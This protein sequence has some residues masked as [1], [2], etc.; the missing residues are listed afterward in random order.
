MRIL[1]AARLSQAKKGQT[2]IDTQDYH[3]REWAEREGH[4]VVAV[5]ADKKRGTTH[6]W[7]RPNL[8]PWMTKPDLLAQYDA[9]LG[10]KIDRLSRGDDESTSLIE[11]WAREH[12]KVLLT[13][14]GLYYPCEGADGIRWDV[15]KRLAHQEWLG[16]SEK[17]K[18][19]QGYLRDNNLHAGGRIP[20]GFRMVTKDG[21]EHKT[22]EPD[23]A[24]AP[25]V[26]QAIDR[27]IAGESLQKVC[28]WL[29]GQGMK[30]WQAE[31]W[32]PGSLK[33]VF[34]NESLYGRMVNGKGRT[35]LRHEG[36]IDK[37]KYDLLQD[38]LHGK[39]KHTG[40]M[41][42]DTAMLTNIAACLNCGGPMYRHVSGRKRAD[43]S[44]IRYLYYRCHGDERNPSQCK[45]M[46]PLEELEGWVDYHMTEGPDRLKP[47]KWLKVIPGHG[48]L[49]ELTEL[50]RDIRELD[51]D[52]PEYPAKAAELHAK[53]VA[54][55]ALPAV[56]D[57]VVEQDTGLTVADY[58]RTLDAPGRRAF[59][60]AS[61]ARVRASKDG[62]TVE[63]SPSGYVVPEAA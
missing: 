27:Y 19:M 34:I 1:I 11:Q 42:T 50:E 18:R 7:D 41:G 55:K 53:R 12:G 23:P 15:M 43:G 44:K 24:K 32:S 45:N 37:T 25:F 56:P 63:V 33:R 52:D 20:Y 39:A 46:I 9:I 29:D 31:K 3:S 35:V 28:K 4:T 5:V 13:A 8:R 36:L 59:L 60:I 38:V 62:A 54:L 16:Y 22:L 2:G 17:Y 14:D 30:P 51:L 61:Q 26:R 10:Y 48:H 49:D 57:R 47:V 6:P 21:S 58:W 40:T